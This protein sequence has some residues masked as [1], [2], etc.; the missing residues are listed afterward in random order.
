[1]WATTY[2]V[3]H[4]HPLNRIYTSH[5]G[6]PK[7]FSRDYLL[8]AG[9]E[10]GNCVTRMR[11]VIDCS[12]EEIDYAE[13]GFRGRLHAMN[14]TQI[15]LCDS[16]ECQLRDRCNSYQDIIQEEKDEEEL[17]DEQK[18]LIREMSV[19]AQTAGGING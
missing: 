15:N 4:T 18:A 17:T 6:I 19:W 8:K 11:S 7:E 3:G 12:M 16:M 14:K 2:T 9:A 10:P 13:A 5:F 1:M